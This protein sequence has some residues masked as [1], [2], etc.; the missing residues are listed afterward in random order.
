MEATIVMECAVLA[1]GAEAPSDDTADLRA[2]DP[3]GRAYDPHSRGGPPSASGTETAK[4]RAECGTGSPSPKPRAIARRRSCRRPKADDATAASAAAASRS[5]P[6]AASTTSAF[7]RCIQEDSRPAGPAGSR[8]ED[9]TRASRAS[10]AESSM[11]GPRAGS[12]QPRHASWRDQG[13]S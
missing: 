10:A 3:A 7:G 12:T 1:Q 4:S 6:S 8:L 13:S 9:N 2:A 5:S 11:L